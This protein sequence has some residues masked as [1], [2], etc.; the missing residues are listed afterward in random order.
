MPGISGY[1]CEVEPMSEGQSQEVRRWVYEGKE[2]YLE[3][4]A[5]AG[6]KGK[7]EINKWDFAASLKFCELAALMNGS[8]S[9]VQIGSG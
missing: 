2:D 3:A 9:Q 7:R 4:E 5:D 1:N 8:G 6:R